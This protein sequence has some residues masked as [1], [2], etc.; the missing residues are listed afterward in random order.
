MKIYDKSGALVLDVLVDDT[1]YR[2]RA[3]KGDNNLTL[4]Y[5]LAEHVELPVGAYCD[6]QGERFTLMNPEALT[7]QHT[8]NFEYT[9][10]MESDQ[11]KAKIWK[12]RCVY[13]GEQAALTDGRLS[14]S[15]TAK[16]HEH[17]QM[18]VDNLNRRET[19][20]TIGDCIDGVEHLISYDHDYIWEALEAI[21]DEFETEF[22]IVGKTISLHKV[23][24][25]KSAPLA[26]SYGKGNGFVSGVGRSNTNDTPPVEILYTQGGEDNIDSA[27]Y[28]SAELHLPKGG[29]LSY[30]GEHFEDEDGYD[31]T[32]ARTYIADELGYSIQRV[33]KTP[34]SYAEDSLDCTEVYPKRVGTVS[35][36]VV[37]DAENNLYDFIDTSIP[38]TLDFS[39]CQIAEEKTTVIFQSGML[40]GREFEVNYYHEATSTK[41]GRRFEIVA[42]EFDG[43]MM[44]ND[45]FKPKGGT[46]GDSYAIFHISLPAAYINAYTKEGDRKEGAEWDMMREAVK[47]LFDN[48]EQKYTFT[49]TLDGIWAKKD[50]T[51]IGGK[52][53]LGGYIE[54]T[55]AQFQK[56]GVLVRITGIKDYINKPYSPEIEI[57][58]DAVGSSFSSQIKTL[59]AQAVTTETKTK[60]A[61]QYARRRYRDAKETMEMLESSLLENFE[62]SIQP[63][64]V[65]TMQAIVGDENLQFRFVSSYDNPKEVDP[66][67]VYN[68]TTKQLTADAGLVQ[69]M[70]LGITEIS[71]KHTYQFWAV[72]SYTSSVLDDDAKKYYLYLKASRTKS[73]ATFLLS[74]TAIAMEVDANY[75]HFLVGVLNSAYEGSRSFAPLYGYT[76]ILPSRITTDKVVSGDGES[77]FD[78]AANAMK[79]GDKL[80]FVDGKLTLKG[81]IVQSQSGTT[82]VIGCYRGTYDGS[83]TYYEGDEV[84]Y[85]V[86]GTTSTYRCLAECKGKVPTETLY[87]QLTASGVKGDAGADVN[88]KGTAYG[89]VASQM[90]DPSS[91]TAG[92][93]VLMDDGGNSKP[94]TAVSGGTE[95]RNV[96]DATTGD[97]YI[98]DSTG[99]LWLATETTWQNVGNIKGPQGK[100]GEQGATGNYTERRFAVNGSSTTPPTLDT[101][102]LEPAGWSLTV[103]AVGDLQY[104]W[105]T[106]AVKTGDGATLVQQWGTPYRT[107]P[108]NGT[109]G[110]DGCSPAMVY[111]GEYASSETYYGT[112]VRVDCVKYGDAYYIA[113]TDAGE[114]SIAP[115]DT[116]KWNAFGAS[117]DS[118]ATNLLLADKANIAGWIFRN[119][120]LESQTQDEDGNPTVYLDG[121]NGEMAL[122]GSMKHA[123]DAVESMPSGGGTYSFGNV[124]DIIT[125]PSRTTVYNGYVYPFGFYKDT[126]GRKRVITNLSAS[127]SGGYYVLGFRDFGFTSTGSKVYGDTTFVTLEPNA[128]IE[129]T[130]SELPKGTSVGGAVCETGGTIRVTNHRCNDVPRLVAV[131]KVTGS[132][133]GATI[134]AESIA[135]S[136][137]SVARG[138]EQGTFTVTM[139]EYFQYANNPVIMLTGIAGRY[140]ILPSLVSVSKNTF[141]VRTMT[142]DPTADQ[143][144]YAYGSFAFTV[145][146]LGGNSIPL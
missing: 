4:K 1:S 85:S 24:Y 39:K 57:S 81:T 100:D 104:L 118:V 117:F 67:I 42:Q 8:R 53:R 121:V 142:L 95:W 60:Q 19:G 134:E 111:R 11:A 84:T 89:H 21:A 137:F 106:E 9:V 97:S 132:S 141:T 145:Y 72:D 108:V 59:E 49:G 18:V 96:T 123:T 48:E 94:A 125:L 45:T 3:I 55:D 105:V 78:M 70:T 62:K 68:A 98:L 139:P 129:L 91:V 133:S 25:N 26:L 16:P 10:T 51:N 146:D 20:W 124:A 73:Q 47:Y 140:P 116:S 32:N 120:R 80:S 31:A 44:P 27:T 54:F 93:L 65:Q 64:A 113:R 52:I 36:V 76:E 114:F 63:I 22:E 107:T 87:W 15:L 46:D 126:I 33:D 136:G 34:T 35:E 58:N 40:A 14:F 29:T 69:H 92:Q 119:N 23:E 99:D 66:N 110:T 74:E 109:N 88:I 17:L 6:Y 122:A 130:C 71:S 61:I 12:F 83:Y 143:M 75:Y 5:A 43:Q 56:D 131:G 38:D 82:A 79:L 135:G 28:G 50:W 90:S 115:P 41:K 77:Y 101:S 86:E 30:D 127:G 138:G 112:S 102:A 144:N 7:M 2:Y 103:P 128:S 37:V 13:S